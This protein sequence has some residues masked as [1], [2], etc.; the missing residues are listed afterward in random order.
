MSEECVGQ[1]IVT[2]GGGNSADYIAAYSTCL[3]WC[4]ART[5]ACGHGFTSGCGTATC[6]AG[7]SA[8]FVKCYDANSTNPVNGRRLAFPSQ[9]ATADYD[10]TLPIVGINNLNACLRMHL[11]FFN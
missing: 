8:L 4:T 3:A 10:P 5:A 2:R 9:E 7:Q 1:K 6:G 11:P